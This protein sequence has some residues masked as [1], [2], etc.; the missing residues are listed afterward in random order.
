[1]FQM[2]DEYYAKGLE[3]LIAYIQTYVDTKNMTMVEIGKVL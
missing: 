2:R 3:D 1:L